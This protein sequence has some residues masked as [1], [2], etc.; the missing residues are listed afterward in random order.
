MFIR[1]PH[2]IAPSTQNDL[3]ETVDLLPT[4]LDLCGL[5]VPVNVQGRSFAPLLAGNRDRYVPREIVFAENAMPCVVGQLAMRGK[6]GYYDY[7]PGQGVDAIRHPEAKMARTARWQLN[8]YATCDGEL[9]DLDNDPGETRNLWA[10]AGSAKI[11][12]ELKGSILDWMITADEKDQIAQRWL[13]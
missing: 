2:R 11:V 12:G 10:D 3:I 9:Y 1:F 8:Y 6:K 13:V 5:P 4:I 7:T